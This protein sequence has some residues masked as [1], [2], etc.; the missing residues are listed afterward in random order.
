M[1]DESRPSLRVAKSK[2]RLS[3]F[4]TVRSDW[5]ARAAVL[6][7]RTFQYAFVLMLLASRSGSSSVRVGRGVLARFGISRDVAGDA[8]T[9]LAG[10]GLVRADR[11][12]GRAPLIVLLDSQGAAL[13]CSSG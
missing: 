4:V 7:G 3:P 6:P 9:R 12:R 10:A 8:L 11:K 2:L 1:A 13:Q 5:L